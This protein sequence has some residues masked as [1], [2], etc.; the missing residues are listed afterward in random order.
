MVVEAQ[1]SEQFINIKCDQQCRCRGEEAER[2]PRRELSV[3]R[4]EEQ[5]LVE[6]GSQAVFKINSAVSH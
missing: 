6:S 5:S 2:H 1:E 3:A 4:M